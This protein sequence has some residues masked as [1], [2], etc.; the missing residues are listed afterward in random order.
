MSPRRTVPYLAGAAATFAVALLL[1]WFEVLPGT[2]RLHRV[3]LGKEGTDAWIQRRHAEARLALFAE[4]DPRVAAGTVCFLGSSTIERWPLEQT[5]PGKRCL[6]RGVGGET[7][8]DLLARLDASLPGAD[9][10]AFIVFIGA[11][12]LRREGA[13]PEVIA[14]RVARVLSRLAERY[15]TAPL[16]LVGIFPVRS[17]GPKERPR[18]EELNARLREVAAAAGAAFIDTDRPPLSSP[19]GRLAEEMAADEHHLSPAG[20]A[21]LARWVL[22]D[23]GAAGRLLAP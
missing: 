7:A 20:Y 5:F 13:P 3:V 22:E 10:A 11:N 15:P 8:A 2:W 16:A 19:D 12:D 9:P 14:G 4:E 1:S 23:G 6:D 17:T 18:L 21:V